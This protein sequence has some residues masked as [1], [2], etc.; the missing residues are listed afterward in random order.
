MAPLSSSKAVYFR[1]LS[2]SYPRLSL[3]Y[4]NKRS[5]LPFCVE[6]SPGVGGSVNLVG[7]SPSTIW[8]L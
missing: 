2:T 5:D 6:A 1:P 3:L 8:Q 4:S 7:I